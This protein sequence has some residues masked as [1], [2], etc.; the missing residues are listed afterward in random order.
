MPAKIVWERL[1]N[2]NVSITLDVYTHA[3][4][5]MDADAADTVARAILGGM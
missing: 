3:L 2:A 1:G 5:V 4:P